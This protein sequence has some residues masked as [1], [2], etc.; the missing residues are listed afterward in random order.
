VRKT[1]EQKAEAVK[2]YREMMANRRLIPG[3]Y[4]GNGDIATIL[5]VPYVTL[6]RW[7]EQQRHYEDAGYERPAKRKPG[8]KPKISTPNP[9]KD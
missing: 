7:S 9:N 5:G 6:W 3:R 4:L 2:R 8:P 1:A